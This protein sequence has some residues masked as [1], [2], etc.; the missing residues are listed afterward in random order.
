MN[1]K[2]LRVGNWVHIGY[3]YEWEYSDYADY[4]KGEGENDAVEPIPLTPEILEKAGW[5]AEDGIWSHNKFDIWLYPK[6]RFNDDGP[7]YMKPIKV[8]EHS[9][10]DGALPIEYVHQLQNLYFALTGEE[11]N[12]RL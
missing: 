12:I 8:M 11:L 3:K 10:P 9:Q 6:N 1:I 5:K 4:W 7:L 2:E